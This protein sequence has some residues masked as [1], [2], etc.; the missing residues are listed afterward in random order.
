M[1]RSL[2][3]EQDYRSVTE[4]RIR[5]V[6]LVAFGWKPL[7]IKGDFVLVTVGDLCEMGTRGFEMTESVSVLDDEK[8]LHRPLCRR[9]GEITRGIIPQKPLVKRALPLPLDD[10]VELDDDDE[11]DAALDTAEEDVLCVR[12]GGV[13]LF[14]LLSDTPVLDRHESVE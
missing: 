10:E 3:N 12:G 8:E 2:H 1:Y 9:S 13:G 4:A 14:F 11:H 7:E 6:E 5:L